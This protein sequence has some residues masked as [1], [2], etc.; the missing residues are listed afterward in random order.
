MSLINDA[1]KRA[2]E[3]KAKQVSATELSEEMRTAD[4]GG[5]LNTLW[6]IGI[7]ALCL[8]GSLWFGWAWWQGGQS[9]EAISADRVEVAART[10]EAPTSSQNEAQTPDYQVAAEPVA[11]AAEELETAP[12]ITA[13]APAVPE[14]VDAPIPT[15]N[16]PQS[17][18]RPTVIPTSNPKP[19]V[20]V[21]RS[22]PIPEAR[23]APTPVATQNPVE[24]KPQVSVKEVVRTTFPALTLQGIYFRPAR[25][26]VVINAQTLYVGDKVAEAKILAIDRHEVTV[27]WNNEVRVIGFQ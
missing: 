6:P 13:P 20:A 2:N 14:R 8:V 15:R 12:Q 17:T 10:H 25:P 1:L 4:D 24:N 3:Q 22:A 21:T 18:P 16:L 23:P 5:D 26:S 9:H 27:Q 11:A 7:F 19:A